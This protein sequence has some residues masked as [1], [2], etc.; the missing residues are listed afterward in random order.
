MTSRKVVDAKPFTYRLCGD[1]NSWNDPTPIY[2]QAGMGVRR[3]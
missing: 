2:A 1:C 3:G